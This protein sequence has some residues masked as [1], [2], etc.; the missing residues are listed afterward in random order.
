MA[1]LEATLDETTSE[2]KAA[3]ANF[4]KAEQRL[5]AAS[6]AHEAAGAAFASGMASVRARSRVL[7]LGAT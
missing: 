6:K 3:Q 5:D 1:S 7:A 4:I 2:L